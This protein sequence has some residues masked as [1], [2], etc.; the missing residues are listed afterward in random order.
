M[1]DAIPPVRRGAH[2]AAVL[3][4]PIAHSLSPVLHRAAY[5]HLGLDWSYEAIEV[6]AD[7]LREFID[8]CDGAWAGLSLTMPL[9]LEAAGLVD[10]CT[11]DVRLTGAANTIVFTDAGSLGAN[12][13][14]TGFVTAL[15]DRQVAD[16]EQVTVIGAGATARSAV[17]AASRLGAS[18][19]RVVARSAD[20]REELLQFAV[21]LGL[22]ARGSG[23]DEAT[24][25]DADLLI[26][27]VPSEA[28]APFAQVWAEQSTAVLF[29]VVYDPWPTSLGRAWAA[30][31][32]PVLDGMDLL[33]HQAVGQVALMTGQQVPASVLDRAGRAALAARHPS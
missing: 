3:G 28:L 1:T 17:V 30:A 23:L 22:E 21:S 26:P 24:M 31:G 16:P 4:S 18:R 14:V 8:G 6:S 33:V 32:H 27:T 7:G 13:D 20:A 11:D 5:A 15:R 12:T 19:V 9:K 10:S 29:D 25:A 2:Q